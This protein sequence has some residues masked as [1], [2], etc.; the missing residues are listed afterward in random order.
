MGDLGS[1]ARWASI[2]LRAIESYALRTTCPTSHR[3]LPSVEPTLIFNSG[4]P[5]SIVDALGN[6]LT[7]DTNQVFYAGLHHRHCFSQ[8]GRSQSGFHIRL[9]QLAAYRILGGDA[10]RCTD[11]AVLIDDLASNFRMALSHHDGAD[12]GKVRSSL[13]SALQDAARNA[14]EPSKEIVWSITQLMRPDVRVGAL[15]SELGWS[16]RLLVA[17]FKDVMG[18]S[19]KSFARMARF[20][21]LIK[22][23]KREGDRAW[24]ARAV[25]AGYFDQAH[26]IRDFREFTG[27]SPR[28]YLKEA[29]TSVQ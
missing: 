26:M 19:P 22:G 12:P 29:V 24:A 27:L 25:A 2:G 7:V 28:A 17:R 11:R 21:R 18:V 6:T 8:A 15:A 20:Q 14:D 4:E 23:L 1:D 3:E 5:I 10:A 16:R 9:S 13:C